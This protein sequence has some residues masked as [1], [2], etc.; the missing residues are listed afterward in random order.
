M[1][2]VVTDQIIAST[3]LDSHGERLSEAELTS[4]FEQ[5]AENSVG[6]SAHDLFQVPAF[7]SF[8][9]RLWRTP[10]GALA[11]VV[12]VEVLDEERYSTFGGYSIAFTR[13][14]WRFG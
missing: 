10:A 12:D 6:V 2:R 4:Y 9:K 11:I 7:R 3:S 13:R 14:H 1:L 8:N 5:I